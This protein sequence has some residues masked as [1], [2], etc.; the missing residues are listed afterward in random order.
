MEKVL[1]IIFGLLSTVMSYGQVTGTFTDARDGHVYKT[2]KIGKQDWMAENLAYLPAVSPPSERSKTS[3]LYYIMSY[4]SGT[5]VNEAKT[6]PMYT[7]YG[8]LYNWSAAKVACPYGWHMPSDDEWKTLTN[9]LGALAGSK[10]KTN[11][12]WME[13]SIATNSSGFSALPGGTL[14]KVTYMYASMNTVFWSASEV[15]KSAAYCRGLNSVSPTVTRAF[16]LKKEGLY[17]RCIKDE[18]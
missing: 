13:P 12:G 4:Y 10:M 11:K 18:L 8:V 7:T 3:P 17:V 2:V 15:G 14:G 1:I 6:K 9:Y 5:S 16:C